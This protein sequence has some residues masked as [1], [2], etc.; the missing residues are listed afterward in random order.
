LA[1][2]PLH[3]RLLTAR[4]QTKKNKIIQVRMFHFL[5]TKA[6]VKHLRTNN[7]RFLLRITGIWEINDSKMEAGWENNMR[8]RRLQN[9]MIKE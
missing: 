3:R 1:E 6:P 9:E 4:S 2:N 8:E 7:N 5:L